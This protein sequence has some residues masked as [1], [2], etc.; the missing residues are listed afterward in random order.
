MNAGFVAE[1]AVI[2]ACLAAGGLLKGAT[3]AG[4]P[5]LAIPALAAVFDVR[6][7]VIVMLVPNLC[8]NLWQAIRFR[9]HV[10]DWTFMLPLLLGGTVG[11][12]LGTMALKAFDPNLLSLGVAIAV[13]FYVAMRISRPHWSLPMG[14]AR[15]L[16]APAGL[17]AGLLQGGAGLSAP[18]S[19]TFLNA[20]RMPRESFIATISS[21]FVAFSVVQIAIASTNGLIRDNEIFYSLFALVPVSLAMPLGARLAHRV[22]PLALDRVILAILAVLAAKLLVEALF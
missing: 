15:W 11:A 10:L 8:T 1:L 6:F 4:A 21:L 3:G 17:L 12:A 14:P 19:I 9:A 13:L 7:A 5:I 16:S 22:S 18:V 2:V 20:L